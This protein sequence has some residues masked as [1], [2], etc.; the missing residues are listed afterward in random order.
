[1]STRTPLPTVNERDT[2]NVSNL[3]GRPGRVSARRP[4]ERGRI[5]L[6][7]PRGPGGGR[8]PERAGREA[9]P[10]R[11]RGLP[12]K[13]RVEAAAWPPVVLRRWQRSGRSERVSGLRYWTPSDEVGGS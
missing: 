11:R 10:W 12:R 9:P 5:P 2:E 8:F 1:M 6:F 4:R 3:G 13:R 7:A